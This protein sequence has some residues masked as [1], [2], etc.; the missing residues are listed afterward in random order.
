MGAITTRKY[1]YTL[2][3]D[4]SRSSG[5][6]SFDPS[7]WYT[8]GSAT[9]SYYSRSSMSKMPLGGGS[10][11]GYS[12]VTV[13]HGAN[14]EYGKTRHRFRYAG[15]AGD[16]VNFAQGASGSYSSGATVPFVTP[17]S[18]EWKR[19][20]EVEVV[21]YNGSGQVQQ[22]GAS[23]Y[24][25]RDEG[26]PDTATTRRFRGISVNHFSS[27][28]L[29]GGGTYVYSP[30]EV[31]SA[32][33]FQSAD[34]TFI[35][36][37]AGSS[38]FS[39]V[40]TYTYA[41]PKH[42]QLT[43]LTETNST[44][45][46]RI[47]RMKYPA[48]YATGSGNV[49]AI[50]LSAMQD[51][52]NMHSPV[53]ERWV[54]QK[55]GA[56]ET[57]LQATLTSFKTYAAGQYLPYQTFVFNNPSG[58]TNFVPSSVSGSFTKDSRYLLQEIANT[59]DVFGRI[60]QLTD[61]RSKVTNYTYGDVNFAFLTRVTRVHDATSPVDL[62]TDIA[63]DNFGFV[64]SI[65]DEGGT[66]R[67]FTYDLYGRLR[68]I[69]NHGS[70]PVRAYGYTYSR[71]SPNWTFNAASPNAIVD[72]TFI[73]PSVSVVNTQYIDGLGRPIQT[74][75][76]DGTNY[77][78]TATQYDVMGRVWRTWNPYT[79]TTAGFDASFTT[80][81]T[82][83]YNT[84]LSVSNAKPYTETQYTTDALSRA[85]QVTP[86]YSGTSATQFV[87]SAYGVD[88]AAKQQYTEVT[89]ESGKRTRTY[90]D[91][92]GNSVKS[93]LGYG[94]T[95]AT[96]TQLTYNVLG[97]RTQTTDPR[98]LNTTYTLDTRGLL[99]TRASPDAGSSSYKYDKGGNPRYTQDANQAAA[100]QV[101]FT[102][103]DFANRP[104]TSGQGAATFSSLDPD[105]SAAFETTTSN[106]LMVRA[107]DAKPATAGFPWSLFSTQISP[108]T[109]TNVSGRLAA[110]ASKSN[111]AWQVTLFS[112]DT[113]GRVATRYTYTQANGG[114]SVLTAVNTTVSYTRDLRA[115]LTQRSLTVGTST[116]Y[117]WYDYDNR[118]LFWKLYASTS[119][120][121]P[122]T[123]D[124]TDTYRPSGQP[125]DYQFLGG[126]LVPIRYTIRG[127][128][129]KVGDPAL[130]TY[131]FSA[132]YAYRPNGTVD[133]AEFYSGGSPAAQKRYRYAFGSG[134][135][136]ALNRLKSADFSSWSG[137]AWTSTLAYD[138]AGINYDVAGNLTALQRYRETATLID[139]LTY[140]YPGTSNRLT[141]VTDAVATTA[142]TWDAET[143]SFTH[144][145]NGNLKT[146]PAPYSITAVTYDPANL[147]LSITRSGTTTTYRYD[148]AGQRIAKQVGTGNT[149]VYILD[150]VSTLGVFTV[151][152]AGS[153]V[154]WF[155]NLHVGDRV[156]G[157]QPNTGSRSYYHSDIL[158]STRAVVQG[159]AVVESYDFEPWG[160]LMPGRTLGSGTKEGLS[161]KE[162]DAET[163]LHYF[164]ARYYMPA[165]GR[166]TSVD[167]LAEKYAEWNPYNYTLDNPVASIDRHG[168]ESVL[169]EG[170]DAQNFFRR[171]R[172]NSFLRMSGVRRPA[173]VVGGG[174][175]YSI[176]VKSCVGGIYIYNECGQF[177]RFVETGGPDR[178]VMALKDGRTIILDGRPIPE[179]TPYR[180]IDDPAA[181]DRI[182]KLIA[183]SEDD[184]YSWAGAKAASREGGDLDFKPDIYSQY[185]VR[186]LWNAGAINGGQMYV[187]GDKIGNAAWA[188]YIRQ[189]TLIP[190]VAA[191]YFARRQSSQVGAVG[192]DLDQV[193]IRRGWGIK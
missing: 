3:S 115:A 152:G 169:L 127:Q 191:L 13:W 150:G 28:G 26:T 174:N 129:Q 67:Y 1:I 79:R 121:K 85:K 31:I 138:L 171:L 32:W 180:F 68:Q 53:T 82:T 87:L 126:P 135:Y 62:V 189:K 144:D 173:K 38:S 81:A 9:C 108:L 112:Y 186:T 47:T 188:Y 119:S 176:Q 60:T 124:V 90:F 113:D 105:L 57:V 97:Q 41:N 102:T 162:Q 18:Q 71:T 101:Y 125:Q 141:S 155:F 54:S 50:A 117:Q 181:L 69:K 43:T 80:S 37:D 103:Y 45:T 22:R 134:G 107:Y 156:V 10:P 52:A 183:Q 35:Y 193:F 159:V 148:G 123:A 160:L 170:A 136:D 92:L 66:F 93:I 131:P 110:V 72:T 59:Y 94:A 46:Q 137:S 118:G 73:T 145:A 39:T 91:I 15:S 56:T 100:G 130:T 63:Y 167:P 114:A 23:T 55:V 33:A 157:R 163:G 109:L 89:D 8:Y 120:T 165:L 158:S 21:E 149:E 153:A 182:A 5:S 172:A 4:P 34:T 64:A 132:R 74:V 58:V 75:V 146:A 190:L 40:R 142:E 12:E 83:F 61:P 166:W 168:L 161:G 184:N 14:G 6:V 17:T 70:I 42:V 78:V 192:E 77:H 178:H 133:T 88:V 175:S 2:Q 104:V 44:G 147:P 106:W 11:V 51:T 143:G 36:N 128:T 29:F 139:N 179:D 65:K 30:F 16:G 76:K 185:G 98:S 154:S 122:G 24:A 48:D 49:E 99:T 95:E 84:Y 140:T 86:Q 96:T 20:Q 187:H 19:G 7:Y 151:N 164:G 177:L 27:G 111:G 116:F 25:F